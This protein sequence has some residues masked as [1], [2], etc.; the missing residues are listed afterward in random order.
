MEKLK[1]IDTVAAWYADAYPTDDIVNEMQVPTTFFDVITNL[2]KV[3]EVL[4]VGDS[5][6]R[7]RVF[8]KLASITGVGYN[9]I[10]NKWLNQ[11]TQ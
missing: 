11:F 8:T 2:P 1:L 9:E 7:E 3:Y 10:Y 4:G 5:I 6:V